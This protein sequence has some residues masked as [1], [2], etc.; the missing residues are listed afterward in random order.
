MVGSISALGL[1]SGLQ[2]QEIL[3]QM[4]EADEGPLDR[5]RSEKTQLEQ[6]LTAFDQI[7]QDLLGIRA[8]A[9]SLSLDSSFIK[10]SVSASEESVLSASVSDGATIGGHQITVSRLATASSWQGPGMAA[11]DGAVN[12]TGGDETFSYQVGDGDPVSLTVPDG[13]TLQGLA[14]L[15][16]DDTGNP[17]VTAAVINDGDS[18]LPYR[19]VLTADSTGETS[20]ITVATQLSGYALTEVQGAE[21]AS[22]NA[23]VV[24]DGITYQRGTNSNILD[25]LGGVTLNLLEAGSTSLSVTVDHTDVRNAILGMVEGFNSVIRSLREQTGY[26]EDGN[27]GLLA[28]VGNA[29]SLR[30][31]LVNLL[32]TSI[33][34]GGGVEDM[35]DLGLTLNRDGSLSLDQTALDQALNEGFE[36]VQTFFLSDD[37]EGLTGFA[38]SVSDRLRELTR[39]VTGVMASERSAAEGRIDRIDDQIETS[40][41]R[42]DRRYEMLARQFA[43]LDSFMNNMQ[44]LSSY[45]TSQFDSINALTTKQKD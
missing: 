7:N 22:L 30:S 4:R 45:L 17:G 42:L 12:S 39:P 19:L 33:R 31:E 10:R 35:Y 37:E 25:I 18:E 5:L 27:P 23:S 15:I 26:D 24:V 36:E 29:R 16:N 32:G 14:D 41:A 9:L 13:T 21:G 2:L 8:H 43:E 20:R 44:S 34:T 11:G 28:G 6:Q 40:T 3:D 38:E 1:G